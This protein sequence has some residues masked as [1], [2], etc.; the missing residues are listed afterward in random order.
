M[1]SRETSFLA[2]LQ[3]RII[4]SMDWVFMG[5]CNR[6]PTLFAMAKTM[7]FPVE[8]PL[9][10]P[11]KTSSLNLETIFNPWMVTPPSNSFKISGQII[12]F[13][14]NYKGTMYIFI[15]PPPPNYVNFHFQY[16]YSSAMIPATDICKSSPFS[17]SFKRW[18]NARRFQHLQGCLAVMRTSWWPWTIHV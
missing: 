7:A 12:V 15:E 9:H 2:A 8:F 10:K 1:R 11:I 13:H 4:I 3:G 16:W 5:N 6:K 17:L 14:Y 18:F